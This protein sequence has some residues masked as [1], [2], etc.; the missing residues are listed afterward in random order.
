MEV[1]YRQRTWVRFYPHL[2][3]RKVNCFVLL[4]LC[5]ILHP[6]KVYVGVGVCVRVDTYTMYFFNRNYLQLN[7]YKVYG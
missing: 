1:V 2:M 7:L 4:S 5:V 3:S 6:V